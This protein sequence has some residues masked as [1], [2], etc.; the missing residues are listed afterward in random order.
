VSARSKIS[1]SVQAQVRQRAGY[2]CEYCHASEQWQYVRFTV[3]HVM[4]L[5]LGGVDD[6]EN[7]A[8]ACF[9]CNR[10]KTNRLTAVD[11]QSNEETPLFNPRR[12]GWHEHFI[13]SAD[14]LLIVALTAVGRATIST[15]V[16]NRE[17]VINIREADK[18]IGRHPPA[19]DPIQSKANENF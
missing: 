12:Q 17:R 8:L 6:L 1:E 16:L 7:L 4:P 9:H 10:R 3:D 11:P 15:L 18:A 2:L 14:G 19:D 5:S 13:W